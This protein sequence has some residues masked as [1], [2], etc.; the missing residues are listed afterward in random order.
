M[1]LPS[2]LTA[3][4]VPFALAAPAKPAPATTTTSSAPPVQTVTPGKFNAPHYVIYADSW[5]AG[6]NMPTVA[7]LGGFNRFVL[8]FD[9]TVGAVDDAVL[10]TQ[11]DQ[12]TRTSI[13]NSYHA[14]GKAIM[15]SAFGSTDAPTSNGQNPVT[16]ANT[17]ANFVRQ[18]QLDGVDIDYEDFNAVNGGT[19]VNWLVPPIAPW[20]CRS[21]YS[22]GAYAA[23]NDQVG[24]TIDFYSLQYYN[25]GSAYTDCNSL[26]FNSAPTSWP[27]TSSG[28][29]NSHDGIPLAKLVLGK[30]LTSAG[31]NSGYMSPSALGS[32]VSQGKSSL[33]WPGSVMFW[34]WDPSANPAGI[35]NTVAG[36]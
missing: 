3:L 1:I 7:Q 2:I 35:L 21:C 18:W 23:V 8:A 19:S 13:L 28:E 10:W 31:A 11:L 34:E 12:N 26:L 15:V 25:Q 20:F 14:A 27:Y 32:C 4:L 24:N 22:D 29:L 6:G 33:G 9:M 30:P 5:L 36:V 16:L 17:I